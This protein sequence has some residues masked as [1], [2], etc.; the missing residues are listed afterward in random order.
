MGY[1]LLDGAGVCVRFKY[2]FLGGKMELLLLSNLIIEYCI[3][4][5]V[6]HLSV[7]RKWQVT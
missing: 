7:Y 4:N 5:L 1:K 3:L 2:V 6:A